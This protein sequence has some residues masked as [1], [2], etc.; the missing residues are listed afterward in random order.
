MATVLTAC[1][2]FLLA[3]LWMDLMFDSQVVFRRN[4]PDRLPES[5]LESISSYYRRAT[6]TSRPM[7]HLIALVMLI[8]LGTLGFRAALGRD[9]GWLLVLS[10]ALAGGPIVLALTHTLP[11]AVRLG[12]RSGPPSAQARVERS[13]LRDHLFCFGC[14]LAFLILWVVNDTS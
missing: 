5:V 13:I 4:S 10:A 2:G 11:N 8:L 3:I 12:R 1:S 6:T 14:M 7:G 9:P